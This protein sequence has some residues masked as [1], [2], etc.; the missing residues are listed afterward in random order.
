[1]IFLI[2]LHLCGICSTPIVVST[3]EGDLVE[4]QRRRIVTML[5]KGNIYGLPGSDGTVSDS[6]LYN[7]TALVAI[8]HMPHAS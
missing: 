6:L 7:C 8:R 3:K 2:F 5:L 4:A 1:M